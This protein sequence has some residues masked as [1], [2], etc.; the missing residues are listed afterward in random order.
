MF[1]T[2]NFM[3]ALKA[4]LVLALT[5]TM[6]PLVYEALRGSYLKNHFARHSNSWFRFI[7]VVIKTSTVLMPLLSGVSLY[8]VFPMA[9]FVY[10]GLQ[11]I[12]D[13]YILKVLK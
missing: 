1:F 6:F 11:M 9:L 5:E 2:L 8:L 13:D 10:L 7:A 4:A 3:L 12:A